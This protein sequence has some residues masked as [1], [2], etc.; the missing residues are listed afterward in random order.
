MT[1]EEFK[2]KW[3]EDVDRTEL[4]FED[5]VEIANDAFDM[6]EEAGFLEA[7]DS[8]YEELGKN[9]MPF[10]VLRRGSYVLDDIDLETLP[11]WLVE[12]ENGEQAMCYPEEIC[13]LEHNK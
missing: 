9:G 12:F 11:V 1:H 6:Y 4:S 7:F 2:Q 8:P 5:A 10:K 3:G 13:K